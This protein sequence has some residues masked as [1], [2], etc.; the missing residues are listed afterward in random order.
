M[1]KKKRIIA[2]AVLLLA[3]AS[4]IWAGWGDDITLASGETVRNPFSL[5]FNFFGNVVMSSVAGGLVAAKFAIDVVK[6]YFQRDEHPSALKTAV[7]QLVIVVLIV[8]FAQ[9]VIL[10]IT[11]S[12]MS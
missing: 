12:S 10:Y 3:V 6:A 11:N 4:Q 5:L 9:A 1:D 2:A 8:L 7:W